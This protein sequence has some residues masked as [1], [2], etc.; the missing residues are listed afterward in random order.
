[1]SP[2]RSSDRRKI[3]DQI[4]SDFQIEIPQA[5]TDDN[6]EKD[7]A[8]QASG[9]F[10]LGALRNSL[11]PEGLQSARFT[12]TAGPDLKQ[13]SGTVYVGSHPGEEQRVLWIKIN[14]RFVPSV[15]TLWKHPRI[16]PLLHTPD[17][18]M[19]KLQGRS[20]LILEIMYLPISAF[21]LNE[22]RKEKC[23]DISVPVPFAITL[24]KSRYLQ[25]IR[26]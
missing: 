1:M 25:G 6:P 22:Y 2:L 18:V 24:I 4:I 14:D 10:G 26:Y 11:L 5:Q 15:Y 20:I 9:A 8:D 7:G 16:V 23:A 17:V 13:V 12:T 21:P 3:A 19:R